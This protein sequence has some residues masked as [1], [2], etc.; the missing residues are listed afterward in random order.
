M[1]KIITLSKYVDLARWRKPVAIGLIVFIAVMWGFIVYSSSHPLSD[2]QVNYRP[3][4]LSLLSGQSPY[5]HGASNNPPWTYVLLAP[6]A[7][8][9]PALG[10]TAIGLVCMAALALTGYKLG[11]KPLPLALLLFTPQVMFL[12]RNGGIDWLIALGFIMPPQIGLFFVLIKPQI[13]ICVALFWFVEAW[14][15]GRMCEVLRV[16]APVG[17]AYAASVAVFGLSSI[18]PMQA[19]ELVAAKYPWDATTF[20]LTIPVALVLVVSALRSR[21][22]KKAILASPFLSPYVAFYSWPAAV[23]GLAG[24]SWYMLAAV[25]GMWIVS[26]LAGQ[27]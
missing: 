6:F 14:R 7:L 26:T 3:P 21:D 1:Q 18:L 24:N 27:F 2:W 22:L 19:G 23:L 12:S 5:T 10:N 20:P 8:F 17:L 15:K 13:G 11:A 9:P 25:A 16:F 4:V